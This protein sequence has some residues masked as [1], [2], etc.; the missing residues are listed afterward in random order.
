MSIERCSECNEPTGNAGRLEDSIYLSFEDGT[1]L[2]PLCA[3]CAYDY[4]TCEYCGIS[5]KMETTASY[6]KCKLCGYVTPIE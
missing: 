4:C 6:Y 2:G 3:T 1:E 5:V